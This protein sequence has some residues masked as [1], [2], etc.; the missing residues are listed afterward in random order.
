MTTHFTPSIISGDFGSATVYAKSIENVAIGQIKTLLDQKAFAGSKICIMPD[1]HAGAGCV[2]GFTGKFSGGRVIP[3]IVG[4]DIGCGMLV[5]PLPLDL[6]MTMSEFDS[7]VKAHVPM[8]M[9]KHIRTESELE[10]IKIFLSTYLDLSTLENVSERVGANFQ[11]V[12][13]SVGTL[14]GGNHFIELDVGSKS[15]IT[16]LVI[17]SGS[18]NLGKRI[19][20]WHQ[21]KAERLI[22]L[23][24]KRIRSAY[25][26]KRHELQKKYHTSD[27]SEMLVLDSSYVSDLAS[28]EVPKDLSYLEGEDAEMYLHDMKIAQRYAMANRDLMARQ[29]LNFFSTPSFS[30]RFHT[31]HNYLSEKDGFIRKGAI[32]AYNGE[33]VLIPMNMRDGCILGIGKGN[34][35]WNNSAPHG[36]GRLL[37]RTQA[38]AQLSLTTFEIEMKGVYTSTVNAGTL[39]ESPMAYKTLDD[40]LPVI[41]ETVEVIDILKSVYN[42]KAQDDEEQTWRKEKIEK[43]KQHSS[44]ETHI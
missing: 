43:A 41:G 3:N 22:T 44:V 13:N 10:E 7:Y 4:V 34:S 32:S 26:T 19:A 15:K 33:L 21:K 17:H 38:K 35:D 18:R 27:T 8:G 39:D 30:G 28:V 16:Y 1:V 12:L 29:I 11:D 2:I 25:M 24:C 42:I 31:I 40:I 6:T 36:A 20:E 23:K 14:G 37:S 9:T 5:Q